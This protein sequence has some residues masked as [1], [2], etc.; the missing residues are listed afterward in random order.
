[1]TLFPT[2]QSLNLTESKP[3]R[4][5]IVDKAAYKALWSTHPNDKTGFYALA[6]CMQACA[7]GDV[8]RGEEMLN[9]AIEEHTSFKEGYDDLEN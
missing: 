7:R 5:I 3:S 6:R 2:K 8:E 4:D 1:M 9:I